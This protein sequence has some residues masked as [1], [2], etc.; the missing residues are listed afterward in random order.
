M[1][2]LIQIES[3]LILFVAPNALFD[4]SSDCDETL[5]SNC[6]HTYKGLRWFEG[7]GSY[8][9]KVPGV[10]AENNDCAILKPLVAYF[11]LR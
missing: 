5:M 3:L 4:R 7:R 9:G 8:R 10:G 1:L 11:K 6:A 2:I